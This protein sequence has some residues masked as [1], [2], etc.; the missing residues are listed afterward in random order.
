MS[1]NF[2]KRTYKIYKYTNDT[3]IKCY[4]HGADCLKFIH[5]YYLN[6][7]GGPL[8]LV[9]VLVNIMII[10]YNNSDCDKVFIIIIDYQNDLP[11]IKR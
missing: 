8:Q 3:R 4:H 2:Y 1:L 9:V 11:Y 6:T 7:L 5:L 10:L